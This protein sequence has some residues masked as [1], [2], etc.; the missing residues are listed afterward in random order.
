[1]S[2]LVWSIR[3]SHLERRMK[4]EVWTNVILLSKRREEGGDIQLNRNQVRLLGS[5]SC[6][7][8]GVQ[9][10]VLQLAG[11]ENLLQVRLDSGRSSPQSLLFTERCGFL[12]VESSWQLTQRR[13]HPVRPQEALQ[14][15][16]SP[17]THLAVLEQAAVN[18]LLLITWL[19]NNP[20]VFIWS[21]ALVTVE[22]CSFRCCTC[23]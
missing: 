23:G 20:V 10:P 7:L 14:A 8:T 3:F 16:Q 19:R 6:V 15:S 13:C 2:H 18:L 17:V 12:L 4:V 9:G 5:S 1:M 21:T 11:Q 22:I